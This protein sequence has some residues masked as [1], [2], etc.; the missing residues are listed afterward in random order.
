MSEV[1]KSIS[2]RFAKIEG[3]VRS[4]K[5]MTDEERSYEEI[6]LQVAAVKKALQSAEKVIF[7]EQMKDMVDSGTYDQK[8]V[9]SFIK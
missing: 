3:H 1:R 2:N 6:M 8:R 5:K 9:D 7:S 4:I